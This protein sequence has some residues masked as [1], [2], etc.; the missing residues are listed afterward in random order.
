VK[1]ALNKLESTSVTKI[2]VNDQWKDN[3]KDIE[4]ALFPINKGK[5]NASQHTPFLQPHLRR[6]LGDQ[7]YEEAIDEILEGSFEILAGTDKYTRMLL[8]QAK[9]TQVTPPTRSY[10][11]TEENTQV[12]KK[13]KEKT[14]AG[15]SGLHF[16][17][18][19]AQ[20]TRKHLSALDASI[21]SLA[22]STGFTYRR[23]QFGIDV[24]LLKI[25]Q[26]YR[27][28]KL[29]AILLLEADVNVNNK[30]L[31]KEAMEI[32]ER[33]N[34]LTRDNYGGRKKLRA[35]EISMI[36]QLTYDSI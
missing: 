3:Q 7:G 16:G 30:K 8:R 20:A 14:S 28:N 18:F 32:G 24:Q 13:A 27:A 4:E 1:I 6:V 5:I 19:K 29:R 25:S 34:L 10:I 2:L 9:Q 23:W 33:L 11:S 15:V 31:G 35:T 12:W 36:Q 17:M 21:R 26:D 22:Y